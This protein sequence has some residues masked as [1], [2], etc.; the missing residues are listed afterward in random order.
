PK[1]ADMRTSNGP[2][3]ASV[4]PATIRPSH[5]PVRP[6]RI[7]TAHRAIP[8]SRARVRGVNLTTLATTWPNGPAPWHLPAAHPLASARWR[9]YRRARVGDA[10]K[11]SK[12][13]MVDADERVTVRGRRGPGRL[14]E[15]TLRVVL[16]VL[17][18]ADV[19]LGV[20]MALWP[21]SFSRTL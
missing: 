5:A 18:L 17:G 15:R 14:D 11:G 7:A 2:S 21:G 4:R 12:E 1:W 16:T 20:W 9:H 8:C 3:L 6:I 13:V 19:A 10:S